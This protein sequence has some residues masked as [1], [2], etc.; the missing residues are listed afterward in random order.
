MMPVW[1]A[2]IFDQHAD[3]VNTVFEGPLQA[4]WHV[5]CRSEHISVVLVLALG[6]T[7]LFTV[8]TFGTHRDKLGVES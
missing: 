3:S 1:G 5:Q 8:S 6:C 2:E 7:P 4:V